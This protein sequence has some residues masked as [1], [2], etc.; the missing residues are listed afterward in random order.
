MAY[1]SFKNIPAEAVANDEA[2]RA[3][4][5]NTIKCPENMEI[6]E[7]CFE[8]ISK[9]YVNEPN[10]YK[11][12]AFRRAAIV[13]ANVDFP[14]ISEKGREALKFWNNTL[15]L[16]RT[17]HTTVYI[18]DYIREKLMIKGLKANVCEAFPPA[19]R[20]NLLLNDKRISVAL[21]VLNTMENKSNSYVSVWRQYY[22]SPNPLEKEAYM[23]YRLLTLGEVKHVHKCV[24]KIAEV[25]R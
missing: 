16:P 7:A 11:A 8:Y 15:G 18:Y 23:F 24:C 5:Q 17:G 1:S 19:W 21:Y 9:N 4:I 3:V 13:V 10:P 12:Y 22:Y 20:N 25:C 2:A 14:L 6:C